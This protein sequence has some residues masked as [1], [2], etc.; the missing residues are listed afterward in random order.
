MSENFGAELNVTWSHLRST[1]LDNLQASNAFSISLR[2]ND[3]TRV[4][5]SLTWSPLYG[6]LKLVAATIWR[7]DLYFVAGPGVVVNPIS[8]GAA[9]NFGVGFRVFLHQA[10]A[11]RFDV[12]DYLYR[13]QLL[14]EDY[15]V[16][17]LAFTTGLSVFLPPKN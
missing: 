15:Y 1:T 17:D 5:G 7:Y 10:V 14:S 4:F 13:Q 6:K 2:R 9:G 3:F 12:R 16:N 8:L 11:L